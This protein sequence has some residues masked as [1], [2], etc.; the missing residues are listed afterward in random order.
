LGIWGQLDKMRLA[1]AAL[2]L[3]RKSAPLR[4]P[5]AR[6][7]RTTV[8]MLETADSQPPRQELLLAFKTRLLAL[9]GW[10]P[11][12]DACGNCGRRA[13]EGQAARFDPTFGAL[14]CRSCG[15]GPV[16]L[17]A[18]T[19][20]HLRRATGSGWA[21]PEEWTVIERQQATRALDALVARHLDR[22]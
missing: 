9:A 10:G 2:E 5:N 20:A 19:R 18:S 8:Q 15:G 3:V 17:S 22:R 7:F 14:V 21:Q 1:G 4:E 11:Q 6:L 16:H 12:L 13:P